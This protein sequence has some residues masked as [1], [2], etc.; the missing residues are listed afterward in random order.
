[1]DDYKLFF[2]LRDKGLGEAKSRI[3]ISPHPPLTT[4]KILDKILNLSYL[5]SNG[6]FSNG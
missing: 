6:I 4:Q 5:T 2:K 1:M 3:K